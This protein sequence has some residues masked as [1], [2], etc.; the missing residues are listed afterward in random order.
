MNEI[1]INT[2]RFLEDTQHKIDFRF[3]I[4]KPQL[5]GKFIRIPEG[6]HRGRF[7]IINEISKD[8]KY[9]RVEPV[10]FKN[11]NLKVIYDGSHRH[12]K[13]LKMVELFDSITVEMF[14]EQMRIKRYAN[15]HC[16]VGNQTG[17]NHDKVVAELD[18][19]EPNWRIKKS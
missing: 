15:I 2:L 13:Q 1:I 14:N 4:L 19:L 12:I 18:R 6:E 5:V 16:L 7:G 9:F 3:E 10:Y 17:Y 8:L 11:G